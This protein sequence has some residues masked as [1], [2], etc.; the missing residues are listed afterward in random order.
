MRCH[1]EPVTSHGPGDSH[2]HTHTTPRHF[3]KAKSAPVSRQADP[4]DCLAGTVPAQRIPSSLVAGPRAS[5]SC[6]AALRSLLQCRLP[7]LCPPVSV[8]SICVTARARFRCAE[9]STRG[10]ATAHAALTLKL[11]AGPP[12]EASASASTRQAEAEARSWAGGRMVLVLAAAA[13]GVGSLG[14]V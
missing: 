9:Y 3:P 6:E 8:A 10:E 5:A 11:T 12:R 14:L 1:C 7:L 2:S 13:V 4:Y